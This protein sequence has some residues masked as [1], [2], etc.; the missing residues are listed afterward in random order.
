M[1]NKT[2][3]FLPLMSCFA[4]ACGGGSS[5]V[6]APPPFVPPPTESTGLWIT[7]SDGDGLAEYIAKL[8]RE[9]A[10]RSAFGEPVALEATQAADAAGSSFSS[11]YTLEAEVDEHDIVK[12]DGST[13]AI[14][15]SRSGCCF[16]VDAVTLESDEARQAPAPL[17]LQIKLF[18]TD[19]VA[20]TASQAGSITLPEGISAEGI[21]LND[22]SLQV[23]L[24]TSWWGSFGERFIEPFYWREQTGRLQFDDITTLGSPNLVSELSVEG[25]LVASRRAGDEVYLIT[26]HTPNIDGLIA[27]P[28]T[29]E[30]IVNNDAIL[31]DAFES[32]VLPEILID[33]VPATPFSLDDCYRVDQEHPLAADLPADSVL[34]TLLTVSSSTGEIL[35]SACIMEPVGGVYVSD[36]SIA[37]TY[38]RWDAE[39]A[40]T[41]VHLL[42]RETYDYLGSEEVEG[43]LYSGGNNDFRISEHEGVLRLVTTERTG[44]PEDQFRHRLFTLRPEASAPEL[45][46]LGVLGDDRSAR[47]GK[48]N[49]DLY[50]VRFMGSRVYLVT[51]ER[52]DPLYVVDL[53]E[54]TSPT[55]VGELEVPGFSDLLHEVNA[56][57]LLGLGSSERRFPKLELYNVADVSNPES[58]SCVELGAVRA[59]GAM[60]PNGCDVSV[61]AE[62]E[63]GYSPAQYN[64]YAFTYLAGQDTDRLTVPYSAGGR[65]D[66]G[67]QYVD[68]VALF[69]LTDKATPANAALN[70]VG[71]I[72]LSPGSVSR[73][74]RVIIDTDALFV[75]AYSDLLSGFWTNPEAVAPIAGN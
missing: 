41:L 28:Q 13:L 62:W 1:L 51:F 54:P 67:Y 36:D 14:A 64:R 4:V 43:A 42:D 48:V 29:A 33:D 61:P 73:G 16:V 74:T 6:T 39:S 57:L 15:P 32:N 24:S 44:N 37:L 19:P 5:A 50:G 30:D 23:L 59:A 69:E 63:W 38:V 8:S 52:I 46:V 34:T 25:G 27:Y 10:A 71:E 11:T 12:Y 7:G 49:E 18:T 66:N 31:A 22:N 35:R 65:V 70:L 21:H 68:R 45:E 55:I 47:I 53:S 72:E 9:S 40:T 26:R 75:I 58:L 2:L 3:L 60:V 17:E 56:E 20:G